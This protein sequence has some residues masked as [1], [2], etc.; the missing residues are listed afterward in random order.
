MKAVVKTKREQGIEVQDAAVPSV[1]ETDILV[2][3][4]AGSL[5]G[6]D[7]HVYEWTPNYEWLPVP[8]ILGH[9]FSG[10]VVEIGSRVRTVSV[11]DHIVAMPGM[12][13][14][15]CEYCQIGQAEL[16]ANR[17]G[18]GLATDGAFAE[19]V[20]L[21][22]AAKTF[23]IPEG[24][25][26]EAAALCEPLS[27]ALHA[28]DVSGI[29]PGQTAA[30]LGP[31]PIGLLTLQCLK[32][33]GPS[34]VMM[35]GT[36]ADKVRLEIAGRLGADVLIDVNHEDPVSRAMALTKDRGAA[37]FDFVFEASGFP[38]NI[39]QALSMVRRGGKVILIGIYPSKAEFQ[40]TEF[41]RNAK[42]LLGSYGGDTETWRRS[43]ALLASGQVRVEPMITHRMPLTEAREGF[44]LAVR[45]EAAKVLFIP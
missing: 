17:K 40:P 31:G 19:Y 9:E 29:K 18:L 28:V 15:Q 3:V 35:T 36:S 1:G 8:I 14:G 13:C 11:G 27:V 12:P 32:A 23:R 16:C 39:A 5:C 26:Y 25:N 22:A 2:K 24:V 38:G 44:E 10:E 34:L 4:H 42:S 21:T 45:K 41:V 37:G 43:L 20:R 7:V 30:I 6:S 33:A